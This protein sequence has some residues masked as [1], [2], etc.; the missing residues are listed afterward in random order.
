M[1]ELLTLQPA[2]PFPA[3]LALARAQASG[4]YPRSNQC[5]GE[6][7]YCVVTTGDIETEE[8]LERISQL[9]L[10]SGVAAM[11]RILLPPKLD[12]IKDLR[13]AAATLRTDLLLVYTLDT[14]FRIE[15]TDIGPLA[16]ISLGFLPNKEARVTSTASAA[17]FDVRTGFLYGVAEG[18]PITHK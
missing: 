9:P 12:S 15:N 2:A 14:G 18:H 10:V 16:L 7:R 11:G 8:D 3:R 5:Y 13:R 1:R 17:L 6:G 4:Y